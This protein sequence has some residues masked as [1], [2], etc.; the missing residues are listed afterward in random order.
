[1][2]MQV[3]RGQSCGSATVG[4]LYIDDIMACHTLEDVVREI[5][6]AP[7]SQWKVPGKT[8]IPSGTY[9]VTL[10]DSPKFGPK[11]LTINDVPGFEKI[12]MHAGNTS[13]DT[14]GCILLGLR[15]TES[16]L[17]GG[18]SRPAVELVKTEVEQAIGD[19]EEVTIEILNQEEP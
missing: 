15:A 18:T 4:T 9:K 3:F 17:V 12:R 19:G 2:K 7:V 16:T 14:E 10:E 11:T 1:M 13:E 8:A 6:C 5:K